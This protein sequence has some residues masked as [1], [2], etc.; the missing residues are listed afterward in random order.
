M[1]LMKTNRGVLKGRTMVYVLR[2]E[3]EI[4]KWIKLGYRAT[5]KEECREDCKKVWRWNVSVVVKDNDGRV[6]FYILYGKP[7][8]IKILQVAEEEKCEMKLGLW[9]SKESITGDINIEATREKFE[10][11]LKKIKEVGGLE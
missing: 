6:S 5:D 1:I 10:R 8:P 2:N 9:K 3:E 11:L 4:V 7:D